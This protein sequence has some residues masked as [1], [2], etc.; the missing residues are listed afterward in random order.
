[1]PS[2]AQIDDFALSARTAYRAVYNT[3]E[4]S[5]LDEG[6]APTALGN[7]CFTVSTKSATVE[8]FGALKIEQLAGR[9]RAAGK[10]V[11]HNARIAVVMSSKDIYAFDDTKPANEGSY[12]QKAFVNVG[13]YNVTTKHGWQTLLGLHYDFDSR[14]ATQAHPI[15]HAQMHD[16]SAGKGIVG[17][18]HTPAINAL[19]QQQVFDSVRIPTANM[20]G[21]SALL[22]LSADHLSHDSFK[23]L[24][25]R[26]RGLA[27]FCNWRCNC[28]TLDDA[29]S[30]RDLLATGWY[31][32][33]A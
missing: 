5:A 10:A 33:K 11:P 30:A 24:L 1:M 26:L 6:A 27:F 14:G 23:T 17:L 29:N 20:V 8:V 22:K 2:Q 32:M 21:A 13:Y 25:Q 31:G 7:E 28:S 12:L 4:R 9:R 19:T 3:F 15:F 18:A 16:G